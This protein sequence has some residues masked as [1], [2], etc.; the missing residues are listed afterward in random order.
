MGILHARVYKAAPSVHDDRVTGE[1]DHL[2]HATSLKHDAPADRGSHGGVRDQ[3]D[4]RRKNKALLFGTI[5]FGRSRPRGLAVARVTAP[6]ASRASGGRVNGVRRSLGDERCR[7]QEAQTARVGFSRRTT[8]TPS[9]QSWASAASGTPSRKPSSP[10]YQS[11][12]GRSQTTR[13]IL[14]DASCRHP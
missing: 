7:R 13:P 14:S 1:E 6:R 3:D 2:C 12:G 8:A 11:T 5:L 10:R 9:S 4:E